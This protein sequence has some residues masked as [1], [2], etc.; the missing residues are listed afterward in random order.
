MDKYVITADDIIGAS[1]D[2]GSFFFS[3]STV[4]FW[5]TRVMSQV[6]GVPGGAVFVT[7]ENPRKERGERA[8][9]VRL[10]TSEGAKIRTLG[11]QY[12]HRTR[13]QALRAAAEYARMIRE[14]EDV[15]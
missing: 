12:G 13:E 8:Y 7:S 3:P 5:G 14:G 6:F 15:A 10:F 1:Q 9:T 11:P 2:A 4:R